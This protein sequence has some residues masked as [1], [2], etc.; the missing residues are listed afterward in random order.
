MKNRKIDPIMWLIVIKI[1][2]IIQIIF[3][4]FGLYYM[5]ILLVYK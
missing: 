5:I 1:S 3:C 2:R 4:N